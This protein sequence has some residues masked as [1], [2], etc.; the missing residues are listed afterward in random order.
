MAF[1]CIAKIALPHDP[2]FTFTP[3]P[4]LSQALRTAIPGDYLVD[5]EDGFDRDE[6]RR[7]AE[8]VGEWVL[9]EVEDAERLIWD[10]DLRSEDGYGFSGIRMKSE[11]FILS[12]T[13]V[14]LK[15]TTY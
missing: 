12:T 6:M 4:H 7:R 1:Y 14:V 8:G 11:L 3:L 10:V 2:P 15:A 9:K 13:S 5:D